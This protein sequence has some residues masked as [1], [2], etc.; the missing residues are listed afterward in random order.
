MVE[1]QVEVKLRTGLQARPAALF[2]QEANRFSSDIFLEKDGKKVNAKSIM[3]LMSLAV[4]TGS[5]VN[6]V[7]DGSDEEEALEELSQYIQQES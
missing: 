6:L 3:G 2:V 7:A 4:S 5:V 1:K